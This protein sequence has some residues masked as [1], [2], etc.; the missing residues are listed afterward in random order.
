M[1]ACIIGSKD[2]SLIFQLSVVAYPPPLPGG[3]LPSFRSDQSALPGDAG[4]GRARRA[5]AR[6]VAQ[7][8]QGAG[9]AQARG[10]R[11]QEGRGVSA[12]HGGLRLSRAA[13]A[14]KPRVAARRWQPDRRRQGVWY[15]LSPL[16]VVWQWHQPGA[17]LLSADPRQP[18]QHHTPDLLRGTMLLLAAWAGIAFSPPHRS[19]AKPPTRLPRI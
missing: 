10:L 3:A 4:G 9:P 7:G 18:H 19:K 8:A 14:V 2:G 6:R 5:A 15:G 11:Q 1:A 16:G 13:H 12:H 17:R